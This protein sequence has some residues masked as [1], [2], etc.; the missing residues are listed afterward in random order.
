L[1]EPASAWRDAAG[2]APAPGSLAREGA[3][4]GVSLLVASGLQFLIAVATM[5]FLARFVSPSEFGRF[6]VP[7]IGLTVLLSVVDLGLRPAIIQSVALDRDEHARLRRLNALLAILVTGALLLIGELLILYQGDASSRPL[8]L[9]LCAA[10]FMRAQANL[11]GAYLER[12]RHYAAVARINVLSVAAGSLVACALAWSGGG[13]IALAVQQF[14]ALSCG[15]VLVGLADRRRGR[16]LVDVDV[17]RVSALPALLRSSAAIAGTRLVTQGLAQIDRLIIVRLGDIHGL[18]LYQNAL[19]WAFVPM[20]MLIGPLSTITVSSLSRVQHDAKRF[21]LATR[22]LLETM[23]SALIPSLVLLSLQAHL[24]V[25]LLLG[26]DWLE[27]I[28]LLQL[29]AL[30]ML[31]DG[32]GLSAGWLHQACGRTRERL[33]WVMTTAPLLVG[34]LWLGG[35]YGVI[36]VA[37]ALLVSRAA[38][39]VPSLLRAA[40]VA[41]LSRAD[42]LMPLLRPIVAT[43]LAAVSLITVRS[44]TTLVDGSSAGRM[45]LELVITSVGFGIVYLLAWWALPGGRARLRRMIGLLSSTERVAPA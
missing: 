42:V 29:L 31:C 14:I 45:L 36:G 4:G 37:I 25:P 5:A 24:V 19:R 18:G 13:A 44:T 3:R 43:A 9:W 41:G 35:R 20:M 15:A 1:F 39:V 7:M 30:A 6:A 28:P 12:Q 16:D 21:A 27:A 40:R 10:L 26:E 2:A 23:M 38:L 17:A 22:E 8:T 33:H 11:A 34:A 32:M